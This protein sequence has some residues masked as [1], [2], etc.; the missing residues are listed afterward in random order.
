MIMKG[1]CIGKMAFMKKV[2][3]MEEQNKGLLELGRMIFFLRLKFF[4][5]IDFI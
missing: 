4:I 1:I 3:F 5:W 2:T